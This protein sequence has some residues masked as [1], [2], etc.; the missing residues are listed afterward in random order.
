MPYKRCRPETNSHD[1]WHVWWWEICAWWLGDTNCL[2]NVKLIQK[3][4]YI[5]TFQP[6]CDVIQTKLVTNTGNPTKLGFKYTNQKICEIHGNPIKLVIYLVTNPM[7]NLGK[8]KTTTTPGRHDH[9]GCSLMSV[10]HVQ[11]LGI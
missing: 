5:V 6:N 2:A 4:L 3:R 10:K 8:K 1:S 11:Q 7:E 9:L